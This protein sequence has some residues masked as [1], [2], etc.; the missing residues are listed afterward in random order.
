MCM[1][2]EFRQR[3]ILLDQDIL[4]V[5]IVP[6]YHFALCRICNKEYYST[7]ISPFYNMMLHFPEMMTTGN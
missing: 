2:L 7:V 4:T 6:I 3:L 1:L 5:V